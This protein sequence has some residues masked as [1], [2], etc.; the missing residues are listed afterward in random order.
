MMTSNPDTNQ[1]QTAEDADGAFDVR[2]SAD[3]CLALHANRRLVRAS[4][5]STFTT[6]SPAVG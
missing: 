6:F 1:S 3:C 4:S 5:V 2:V